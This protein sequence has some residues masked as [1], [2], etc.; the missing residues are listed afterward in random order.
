MFTVTNTV[1]KYTYM[2]YVN[3]AVLLYPFIAQPPRPPSL[4]KLYAL[5]VYF[6]MFPMTMAQVVGI[7]RGKL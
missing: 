7:C 5:H 6:G 3:N 4:G 1:H 2:K